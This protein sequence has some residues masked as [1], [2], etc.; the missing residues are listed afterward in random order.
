IPRRAHIAESPAAMAAYQNSLP[1]MVMNIISG[2]ILFVAAIFFFYVIFATALQAKRDFS[3]HQ[4][5]PFTEAVSKPEGNA[6]ALMTDRVWFWFGVAAVLILVA[7][8]PVLFQMFTN[9]NPVP[10]M[11]LW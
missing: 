6:L 9:L 2:I 3:E 1:W 5:I 7:Y 10:G 11:R 8:G 4:E